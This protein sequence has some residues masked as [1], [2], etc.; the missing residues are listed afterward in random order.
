MLR[1][2]TSGESH[3]DSLMGILEGLPSNLYIDQEFI[4]EEL[5]KRQRGYGR[6]SRM[7][8]EQ[9]R[10]EILSGVDSENY[11][12]GNPIGILIKNRGNNI[13]LNPV[14]KPRPGHADLSG[15]LK[16]NQDSGRNALER[17]S[18]RET[19]M[20]VALGAI[21]KLL[22][23]EF[24]IEIYSHVMSI[25]RV[26]SNISYYT[27][28]KLR[29]YFK[30]A[31]HS[32]MNVLDKTLELEMINE[33]REIGKNRDTVGGVVELVVYG[34]PVGLGSYNSWDNR[35]DGKLARGLMSI[36]AIKGVEIGLGFDGKASL[37]SNYH[38]PILYDSLSKSYKRETNYAGGLE[39]GVT[40]GEDL[41]MSLV[42]KPI[43]TLRKPLKTV[44]I[45]TKE[46]VDAQFERSDITAVPSA[47]IV[48]EAMTAYVLLDEFLLKFGGD[49]L[50]E[51]KANYRNYMEIIEK[52]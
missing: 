5:R 48:A 14:K 50:E 4:N 51:L 29:D 7:S 36:P 49:S 13:A 6:G 21:C 35:I 52:R 15:L 47:S 16:Y 44:D 22:L 26:E 19:A 25:G 43:P 32:E 12:T 42:M 30:K 34:L 24:G 20:R 1:L 37:G 23:R 40:N 17:A 33:V 11:S 27:E 28:D 18:A 2:I 9:D 41:V 38:D 39:A 45:D 8:I 10:V 46:V 3:G 31:V